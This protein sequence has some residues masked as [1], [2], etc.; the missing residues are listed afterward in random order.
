MRTFTLRW[1]VQHDW[2]ETPGDA[3]GGRCAAA[4]RLWTGQR[5]P[6]FMVRR[7]RPLLAERARCVRHRGRPDRP[8]RSARHRS[9][10]HRA[11]LQVLACASGAT[12]RRWRD[13][14]RPARTR[15]R[16]RA[17]RRPAVAARP[18]GCRRPPRQRGRAHPR[19]GRVASRGRFGL[20]W[21]RER[22]TAIRLQ[23]GR[24]RRASRR[25]HDRRHRP[26]RPGPRHRHG[27]HRGLGTLRPRA[28]A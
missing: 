17:L 14:L 13:P 26:Q 25:R 20:R 2:S 10:R 21:S 1:S 22:R 24:R 19:D 12:P 23:R 3:G 28:P 15:D 9:G 27:E 6:G 16:R 5:A 8:W 4:A 7:V 11:R 18:A